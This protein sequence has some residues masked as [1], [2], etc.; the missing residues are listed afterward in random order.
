MSSAPYIHTHCTRAP[1]YTSVLDPRGP[2]STST[3]TLTLVDACSRVSSRLYQLHIWGVR[4]QNFSRHAMQLRQPQYAVNS[5]AST[6][7]APCTL[8]PTYPSVLGLRVLSCSHVNRCTLYIVGT[9]RPC[10]LQPGP[11]LFSFCLMIQ[12]GRTPRRLATYNSVEL[13]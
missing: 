10:S 2:H 3:Q 7:H 9:V 13:P 5:G 11:Y 6:P 1:T 8:A 4:L 12:G